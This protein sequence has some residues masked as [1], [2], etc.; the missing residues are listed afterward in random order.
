MGHIIL[1]VLIILFSWT[2]V[3]PALI[4]TVQFIWLVVDAFLVPGWA[5]R[6]NHPRPQAYG[7]R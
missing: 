2:L 3:I 1:T 5:A 4:G 6:S 7:L